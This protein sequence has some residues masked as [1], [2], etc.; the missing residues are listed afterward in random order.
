VAQ[1][2]AATIS[3]TDYV[4]DVLGP[5]QGEAPGPWSRGVRRVFLPS[6]APNHRVQPTPYSVRCAPASGSR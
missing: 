1:R 6:H 2:K 3:P 4:T 5:R